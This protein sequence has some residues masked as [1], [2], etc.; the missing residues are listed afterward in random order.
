MSSLLVAALP[1]WMPERPDAIYGAAIGGAIA[2][3]TALLTNRNARRRQILDLEHSSSE[4]DKERH[5]TL[6]R[7]TYLPLI[8]ASSL[9]VGFVV[10]IPTLPIEQIKTQQP[11]FDLAKLIARLGLIAPPAVQ[12]PIQKSHI[13]LT[14]LFFRLLTE[15]SAI[16][17]IA[18]E[19]SS[20]DFDVQLRLNRQKEL[21]MRQEKHIDG[22]TA[23]EQLM[24]HLFEQHNIATT[25]INVLLA[26]RAPLVSKKAEMEID[27]QKLAI[28]EV[29]AIARQS[30]EALI[31]IRK[32][33]GLATDEEWIRR[34]TRRHREAIPL[35][36][37]I[38][39]G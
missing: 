33:L 11:L 37:A 2:L 36:G 24:K 4:K 25:E 17:T 9:A 23:D 29:P 31:A 30:T 15:R 6:R 34:F 20:I 35:G 8:E 27:L 14:A 32:D 13:L 19:I 39:S 21:Q 10:Q 26:R 16:E 5:Y 12:E 1:W 22:K 28:Q 7:E 38:V 3:L 18:S